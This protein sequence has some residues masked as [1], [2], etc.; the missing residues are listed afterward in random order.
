MREQDRRSR[1][2]RKIVPARDQR[3]PKERSGARGFE[4]P[5]SR[6][7]PVRRFSPRVGSGHAIAICGRSGGVA[8]RPRQ[9]AP[10]AN[11]RRV[12]GRVAQGRTHRDELGIAIRSGVVRTRDLTSRDRNRPREV[13]RSDSVP[14]Q[15]DRAATGRRAT[16]GGSRGCGRG[17]SRHRRRIER[18]R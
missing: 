15:G 13:Q 9:D 6:A 10:L 18:S 5:L 14:A 3:R 16:L 12:A 2:G 8:V 17:H 1:R 11:E 4:Q 7:R